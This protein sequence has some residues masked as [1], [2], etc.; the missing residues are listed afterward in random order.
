MRS[1]QE[2]N[3]QRDAQVTSL[4]SLRLGLVC[5]TCFFQ[6]HALFDSLCPL[7]P[8]AA[9]TRSSKI[10]QFFLDYPWSREFIEHARV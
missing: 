10:S 4:F 7:R 1:C 2:A 9:D 3:T 8:G 6:V 5:R